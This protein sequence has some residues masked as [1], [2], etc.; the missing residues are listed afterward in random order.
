MRWGM[1]WL[2]FGAHPPF[3]A[4]G[5]RPHRPCHTTPLAPSTAN[6]AFLWSRDHIFNSP[7]SMNTEL[8]WAEILFKL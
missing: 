8:R 6:D 5:A 4:W 2:E 3:G 7:A 1:G